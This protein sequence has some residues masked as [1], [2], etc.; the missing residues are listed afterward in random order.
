VAPNTHRLL[1]GPRA[2]LDVDE[3]RLSALPAH[4]PD[5]KN[6]AGCHDHVR[7]SNSRLALARANSSGRMAGEPVGPQHVRTHL[8]AAPAG[9]ARRAIPRN[10]RGIHLD[11]DRAHVRG[12]AKRD[13][14]GAIRLCKRP[15]R[16]HPGASRRVIGRIRRNH[17]DAIGRRK[18]RPDSRGQRGSTVLWRR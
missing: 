15:V 11:H 5:W 7:L 6:Q 17:Q 10:L 8:V 14:A 12:A 3:P 18:H 9:Q 16:T 13:E 1:L 2:A 4:R